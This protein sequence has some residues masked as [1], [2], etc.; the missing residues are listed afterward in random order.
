MILDRALGRDVEKFLRHEQRDEGHHLQ[1]RLERLELLPYLRPAVGRRLI[2]WEFGCER[3]LLERI[4]LRALLLRRHVDRDYVVA[5]LAQRLQHRLAE[6]L[7]AVHHDTHSTSL[8]QLCL[9]FR[10]S[11][12][13]AGIH[14]HRRCEISRSVV[15]GPATGSPRRSRRGVPLAG[16]TAFLGYA[17][18]ARAPFS[19]AVIAPDALISATSALL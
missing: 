3:C 2:D 11:E 6:R 16:T 17:A 19:G 7:L 8:S 4:G 12:A 13:R 10:P 15:M 1:V 18:S 9:S 5:A 14:I